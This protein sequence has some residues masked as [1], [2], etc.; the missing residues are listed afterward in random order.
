M[1][2]T[3]GFP[4]TIVSYCEKKRPLRIQRARTPSF[5]CSL[6]GKLYSMHERTMKKID[7]FDEKKP[8]KVRT[9][10]DQV[11][12]YPIHIQ[13]LPPPTRTSGIGRQ[14]IRSTLAASRGHICNLH[15]PPISAQKT[16]CKNS[17]VVEFGDLALPHC[18]PHRRRR[19]SWR[20]LT[21][22]SLAQAVEVAGGRMP[23]H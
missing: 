2:S 5:G 12:L 15:L 7:S 19:P 18:G 1:D 16:A 21:E 14:G 23:R 3:Y 9:L 10:L 11:S 20:W 17:K 13:V 22:A 6:P 4:S 8:T